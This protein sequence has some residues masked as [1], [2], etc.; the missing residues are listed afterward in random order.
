MNQHNLEINKRSGDLKLPLINYVNCLEYRESAY[1]I[2]ACV[3]PVYKFYKTSIDVDLW[4]SCTKFPCPHLSI[5]RLDQRIPS[6]LG[7]KKPTKTCFL[8]LS[9]K[10][11]SMTFSLKTKEEPSIAMVCNSEEKWIYTVFTQKLFSK[12]ILNSFFS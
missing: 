6:R 8:A 10:A 5:Y 2:H 1:N 4:P 12:L 3:S 9:K 7:S 11:T